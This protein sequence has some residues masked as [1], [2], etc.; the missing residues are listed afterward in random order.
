VVQVLH[1]GLPIA[2]MA[3]LLLARPRKAEGI[4]GSRTPS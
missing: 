4:K 1:H 2:K 3:Q